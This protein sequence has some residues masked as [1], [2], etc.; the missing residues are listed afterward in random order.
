M[1]VNLTRAELVKLFWESDAPER[2]ATVC[3]ITVVCFYRQP[4]FKITPF[5][6][7]FIDMT[8]ERP[9]EVHFQLQARDFGD[10]EPWIAVIANGHVIVAPFPL[11]QLPYLELSHPLNY[12]L[13]A[14]NLS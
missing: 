14:S 2:L 12:E 3:S 8:I 6:E 10:A 5:P 11:S 9:E 1:S 7:P 13:E 4:E